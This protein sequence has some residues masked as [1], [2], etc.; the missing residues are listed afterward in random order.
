MTAAGIVVGVALALA[1]LARQLVRTLDDARTQRAWR[2]PDVAIWLL[3]PAFA[4]LVAA[5]LAEY[6]S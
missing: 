1:L 5:Q 3:L 6:M 4:T 2:A